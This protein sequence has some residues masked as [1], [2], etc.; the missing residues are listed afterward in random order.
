MFSRAGD[1]FWPISHILSTKEKL[2]LVIGVK[3]NDNSLPN[4]DLSDDNVVFEGSSVQA[5]FLPG[6]RPTSQP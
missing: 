5:A 2:K 4:Y 1:P 6:S 3:I